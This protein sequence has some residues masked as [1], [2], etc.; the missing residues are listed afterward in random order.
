MEKWHSLGNATILG[1]INDLVILFNG[2]LELKASAKINGFV[3]VVGGTLTQEPGAVIADSQYCRWA[4]TKEIP[5][6]VTKCLQGTSGNRKK[7]NICQCGNT[8]RKCGRM[9]NIIIPMKSTGN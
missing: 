7:E 2:N 3:L 1:T 5:V 9:R 4:V 8:R 6:P